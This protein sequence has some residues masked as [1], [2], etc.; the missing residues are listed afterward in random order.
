M[1]QERNINNNQNHL[2]NVRDRLFHALFFK[3]AITYARAFPK[4]VRR[5]F[6][7]LVLLK[8]MTLIVI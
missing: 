7:F 4:P 5:V 1:N 3:V 6:E 8:V 2:G